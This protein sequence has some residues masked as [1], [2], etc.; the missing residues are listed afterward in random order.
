MITTLPI[1]RS[2][3][4]REQSLKVDN[5][6]KRT[7]FTREDDNHEEG[8]RIDGTEVVLP[9]VVVVVVRLLWVVISPCP[10]EIATAAFARS[11]MV[12]AG[13]PNNSPSSEIM[14]WGYLTG[15]FD[16]DI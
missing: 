1:Q 7:I 16:R 12:D 9:V 2:L 3:I 10:C 15:I 11:R 5:L 14:M 8:H 13:R 6:Y 4:K